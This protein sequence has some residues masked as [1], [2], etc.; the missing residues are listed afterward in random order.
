MFFAAL[1]AVFAGSVFAWT[2]ASLGLGINITPGGDGGKL[3]KNLTAI[4]ETFSITRGA[5]QKV[6]GIELYKIELGDAESSNKVTIEIAL[7]NPEDMGAV[8]NN[9]NAFIDVGVY[10]PD[11][12]GR[13]TLDCDPVDVVSRD[14]GPRASAMMSKV[15]GDVLL[16]PSVTGQSTLY[17]LAS[18]VVPGGSPPGQQAQLTDLGF[19]CQVKKK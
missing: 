3:V 18:I 14:E 10:Y 2:Q 13:V 17:I 8:L 12:G 4:G 7:L 1:V 9:P 19:W 11:A 6:S 15:I 5:A 16:H